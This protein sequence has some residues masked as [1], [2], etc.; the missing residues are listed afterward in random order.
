[1]PGATEKVV[2][3]VSGGNA[4]ERREKE[5]EEINREERAKKMEEATE[6]LVGDTKDQEVRKKGKIMIS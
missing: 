5:M 3:G 1:M 2:N 6:K 4:L